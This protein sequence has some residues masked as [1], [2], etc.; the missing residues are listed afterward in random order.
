MFCLLT[1]IVNSGDVVVFNVLE[2]GTSATE[3]AIPSTHKQA[4]ASPQSE[5]WTVAEN[6]EIHSLTYKLALTKLYLMTKIRRFNS[7]MKDSIYG[8]TDRLVDKG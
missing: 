7:M 6:N 8:L 2:T 3:I 5:K 4:I 1:N